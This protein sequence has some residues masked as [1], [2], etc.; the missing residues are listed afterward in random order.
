[1]HQKLDPDPFLILINDPNQPLH[2]RNSFENK[3]IL[4]ENYQKAFKNATFIFFKLVPF[5]EQ[6]YKN[7]RGLKLLNTRFSGYKRSS[8]KL[9]Y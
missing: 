8:E 3:N 9:L 7:K 2:A 6:D 4:K 1:M 5:N